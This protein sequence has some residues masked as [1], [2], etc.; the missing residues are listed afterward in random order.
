MVSVFFIGAV[1]KIFCLPES[2]CVV[3]ISDVVSGSIIPTMQT[4][5]GSF[6]GGLS[7]L[8]GGGEGAC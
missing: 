3:F 1:I 5:R 4:D 2:T 8:G 7:L 6:V